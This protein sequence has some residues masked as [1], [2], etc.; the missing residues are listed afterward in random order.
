M[1][2]VWFSIIYFTSLKMWLKTYNNCNN[3][4]TSNMAT[5]LL[6]TSTSNRLKSNSG[7][8]RNQY[9]LYITRSKKMGGFVSYQSF[10]NVNYNS[11]RYLRCM[12]TSWLP[13]GCRRWSPSHSLRWLQTQIRFAFQLSDPKELSA[14]FRIKEWIRQSCFK[15]HLEIWRHKTIAD[16]IQY[17]VWPS[18]PGSQIW[19]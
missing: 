3:I 10:F 18:H 7:K 14:W 15:C 13:A 6:Q 4:F 19:T 16:M 9:L 12:R 5:I 1:I 8:A 11:K 17:K 2:V